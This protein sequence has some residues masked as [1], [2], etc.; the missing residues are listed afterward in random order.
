MDELEQEKMLDLLKDQ[1]EHI[2]REVIKA[3]MELRVAAVFLVVLIYG[4]ELMSAHRA[5]IAAIIIGA[6]FAFRDSYMLKKYGTS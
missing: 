4:S 6:I 1:T 3:K 5:F 2:V